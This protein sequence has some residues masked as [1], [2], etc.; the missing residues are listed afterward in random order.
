MIIQL[1]K[2]IAKAAHITEFD[3][4]SFI[5]WSD[6]KKSYLG[7]GKTLLDAVVNAVNIGYTIEEIN[8][9]K[10]GKLEII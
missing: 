4:G 10:I 9:C 3:S 6:T 8:L 5:V 2:A 1:E 7:I